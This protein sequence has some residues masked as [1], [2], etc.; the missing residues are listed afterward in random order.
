MGALVGARSEKTQKDNLVFSWNLLIL[1]VGH[2]QT[3]FDGRQTAS[4]GGRARES[5]RDGFS[6]CE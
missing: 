4:K 6:S 1:V 2:F 3:F 5:T